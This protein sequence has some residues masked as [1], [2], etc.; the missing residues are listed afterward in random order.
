M[1]AVR[2]DNR[3]MSID[4]EI[5]VSDVST[6]AARS[7]MTTF[8]IRRG[9]FPTPYEIDMAAKNAKT[10]LEEI[11]GNR[12]LDTYEVQLADVRRMFIRLMQLALEEAG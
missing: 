3:D 12:N 9:R 11:F 4:I 7:W 5:L 2:N 8:N 1:P 10:V 6:L